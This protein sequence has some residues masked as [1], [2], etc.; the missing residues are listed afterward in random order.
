MTSPYQ[1]APTPVGDN[2]LS[3]IWATRPV[4]L[5]ESQGGNAK[6]AGVCE[7]IAV[8]YQID[9]TIVRITFVV[10]S[11][12]LGCGITAYLLAWLVM[13]RYSKSTSPIEELFGNRSTGPKNERD[14]AI[15]LLIALLLFSGTG[16]LIFG[17]V[18]FPSLLL[19]AGMLVGGA[20]L[21]HKNQPEPPAGL[22]AQNPP[23]A[24]PYIDLSA[25]KPL[26]GYPYPPGRVTPPAW[27]PLGTVPEAWHLPDPDTVQAAYAK[28]K[29]K[30]SVTKTIALIGGIVLAWALGIVV[31]GT[32]IF[33]AVDNASEDN[34]AAQNFI[35]NEAAELN[36]TYS[37]GIGSQNLDFSQVE[38]IAELKEPKT[39]HINGE[40]G[41]ITVELP[42]SAPVN[43]VCST[44]IGN[45]DCPTASDSEAKLTFDIDNGIGS[46]HAR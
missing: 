31:L 32:V 23:A 41:E 46:I 19:A 38:G 36:S 10:A 39:V 45:V 35:S 42:Q 29:K 5:P 34:D 3:R 17:Q 13:P 20:Y 14:L 4:R 18:P 33:P 26:A 21:L 43:V 37:I 27:D 8:R 9:P 7:G 2:S 28:P 16:P 30:K 12:V 11:L 22:L 1:P 24:D 25:F 40:I 15:G 6:V 44:G